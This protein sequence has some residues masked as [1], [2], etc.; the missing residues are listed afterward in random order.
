MTCTGL[1]SRCHRDWGLHLY[2]EEEMV[3]GKCRGRV[4]GQNAMTRVSRGRSYRTCRHCYNTYHKKYR[5]RKEVK[6]C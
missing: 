5:K 2:A 3:C 6:R 1:R 4:T